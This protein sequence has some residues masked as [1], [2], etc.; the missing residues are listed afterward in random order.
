MLV[1]DMINSTV[2]HSHFVPVEPAAI[3]TAAMRHATA[4]LPLSHSIHYYN[5]Q[6]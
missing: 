2:Q 1:F 5:R 4:P 3:N 6:S